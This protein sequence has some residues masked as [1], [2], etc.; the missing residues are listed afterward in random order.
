[1]TKIKKSIKAIFYY[2]LPVGAGTNASLIYR[3]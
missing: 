1:M 3:Y 2:S